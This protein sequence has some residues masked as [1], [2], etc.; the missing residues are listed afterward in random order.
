MTPAPSF[1]C[2]VC[3]RRIGKTRGHFLLGYPD[4]PPSPE[5]LLCVRCMNNSRR[6]HARY[7]PDCPERWHD[8]HD[9][10]SCHA[11][12]AAAAKLIGVWP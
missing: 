10:P 1:D 5:R 4:T 6:L 11:T 12:R 3:G 9:H 8:L 2:A 7:Y